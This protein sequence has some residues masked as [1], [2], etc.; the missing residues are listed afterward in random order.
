MLAT[1]A[2]AEEVKEAESPA[3]PFSSIG[4][5]WLSPEDF[6]ARETQSPLGSI[7]EV[8]SL[9]PN[10]EMIPAAP[11]RALN[12]APLP[13]ISKNRS[14]GPQYESDVEETNAMPVLIPYDNAAMKMGP[15]DAGWM[16]ANKATRSS[17]ENRLAI[18]KEAT[19]RIRLTVLPGRGTM[20]SKNAGSATRS[21]TPSEGEKKAVEKTNKSTSSATESKAAPK[22]ETIDPAISA[23]ISSYKKKQLEAIELDN[24]TLDALHKAISSLGASS[25][26]GFQQ[27]EKDSKTPP[28]K[29]QAKK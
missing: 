2:G 14:N 18:D 10:F 13:A 19:S 22:K 11:Q 16:D 1:S 20:F 8:P 6:K 17:L 7:V 26:V 23:A 21:N 29:S 24:K 12:L 3:D 4:E 9:D 15:P 28:D 5:K 25:K 27:P